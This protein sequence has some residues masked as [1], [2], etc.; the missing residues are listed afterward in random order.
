MI[1]TTQWI[2]ASFFILLAL[3]IF[4]ALIAGCQTHRTSSDV[5]VLS[6]GMQLGKVSTEAHQ[7]LIISHKLPQSS[8]S[9]HVYIEGD[10]SPWIQRTQIALDPSPRRPLALQ[11]MSKDTL[12]DTLYLGRPCYFNNARYGLADPNC[13]FRLWTSDRYGEAVVDSMTQALSAALSSQAYD[14]VILIGYSGGGTLALLMAQQ[15]ETP[16]KVITL[17]ANLDIDAWTRHHGYTPLYGSLNPARVVNRQGLAQIHWAGSEDKTVMPELNAEFL[18]RLGQEHEVIEGFDHACCWL[19][20]WP[21]LL[22]QSLKRI[23]SEPPLKQ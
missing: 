16:V 10:G 21:E 14:E 6:Y 15:L 22:I 5:L 7:H 20:A 23:Q 9:L 12:A 17:G 19:E 11:L 18:A 1:K 4:S 2:T 3:V 8:Q 13:H